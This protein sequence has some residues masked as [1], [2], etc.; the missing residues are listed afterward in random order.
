[1]TFPF[2]KIGVSGR[3]EALQIVDVTDGDASK[4]PPCPPYRLADPEN[5]LISLARAWVSQSNSQTYIERLPKNYVVFEVDQ[6]DGSQTYK[7]LFGHP[8]GR[9][10]DS[11]QKFTPHF[12][13][14]MSLMSGN[15]R[16][17]L[18]KS[19]GAFAP[20]PKSTIQ[21]HPR[22]RVPRDVFDA[23]LLRPRHV[24]ESDRLGD[25]SSG[26][27]S[28]SGIGARRAR[29]DVR[30]KGAPAD[31]D[32][33]GTEDVFKVFV[34]RLKGTQNDKKGIDEDIEE[35]FSLDWRAEHHEEGHNL[36]PSHLTLIEHQ[37]AFLP[38]VGELVLFCPELTESQQPLRDSE[39]RYRVWDP[40]EEKFTGFPNWRAGVVTQVPVPQYSL[41]SVEL[42]DIIK[43]PQNMRALNTSGFRVETL[44]DPNEPLDKGK[45]KQ[46]KWLP[47]LNLRPLVQWQSILCGIADENIHPSVFNALTCCTTVSLINKFKA[48]GKWPDGAIHCS[49]VYL[50]PELITIGDGV[51]LRP[52]AP[53]QECQDILKVESIRLNL[54]GVRPEHT[55]RE[56]K[57]LSTRTTI[58]LVGNVFTLRPNP[59]FPAL[60]T[61]YIQSCFRI[62]GVSSYGTWHWTH[63]PYQRIEVS[64]DEVLGRLY[65]GPAIR[66]W[67]DPRLGG[68]SDEKPSLESHRKGVE[69]ARNFATQN[70]RR[71]PE[72]QGEELLWF[73]ADT[74]AEAL[75]VETF[76]GQEVGK[77]WRVRDP[78]ELE[79]WQA[80]MRVI[81]GMQPAAEVS[82]F[83]PHPQLEGNT[84]GRKPGSKL[85]NGK[86][87][88]PGAPEYEAAFGPSPSRPK[89]SSQMAGAAL[90]S[91]DE[92]GSYDGDM[93]IEGWTNPLARWQTADESPGL[94]RFEPASRGLLSMSNN[95]G[96]AGSGSNAG[97]NKSAAAS[98]APLTKAQIM[99][100]VVQSV[101]AVDLDGGGSSESEDWEAPLPLARGGTEESSEGDYAPST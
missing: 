15:C 98:K 93:D 11:I 53:D 59:G 61:D 37:P 83:V 85:V 79:S 95:A 18:C 24:S 22:Q 73:W 31:V 29:R 39:G 46:I 88:Y 80:Q 7:R 89:P 32:E 48:T 100:N 14:L 64:H 21:Q 5:Y 86:V 42:Q 51:R 30:I 67:E 8:S 33:E 27:E 34:R 70:D 84:R 40:T 68:Q 6:R 71:L 94:E 65:E 19:N 101:E 36:M 74:R 56:S 13:W 75:A 92:E 43:V 62:T 55:Q 1:M 76:N 57:Q 54:L 90:V 60:S 17:Q 26:Y 72:R 66:L 10:Y 25:E 96:R 20:R 49:G 38:R 44:P 28:A 23:D 41:G 52:N 58:T 91:T 63:P 45:S 9:Y 50:G 35:K 82:Q 16:C 77:H 12:L 87:V 47:L 3:W 97:P 2:K 4:F 69:A 99:S 78:V 81:N